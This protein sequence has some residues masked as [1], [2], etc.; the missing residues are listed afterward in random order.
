M[1]QY[2][3]SLVRLKPKQL[4]KEGY[5]L[6]CTDKEERRK[7]HIVSEGGMFKDTNISFISLCYHKSIAH[8]PEDVFIYSMSV[9]E[10][11]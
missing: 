6:L 10:L 7:N 9:T 3:E 5:L 1:K 11:T 8:I 4:L 2:F